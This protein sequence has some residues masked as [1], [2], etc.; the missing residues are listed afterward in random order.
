MTAYIK[1]VPPKTCAQF[2]TTAQ[3][4]AAL[5]V[6]PTSLGRMFNKQGHAYGIVP[7]KLNRIT[8]WPRAGVEQVL[9]HGYTPT[10]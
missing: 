1:T 9:K 7:I 4:A 5:G 6:A 8:R 3:F 2:Y 10:E